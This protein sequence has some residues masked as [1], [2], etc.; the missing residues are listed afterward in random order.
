LTPDAD[1]GS[2]KPMS[3]RQLTSAK[4]ASAP[5]TREDRLARALRANLRRRKAAARKLQTGDCE[6]RLP[7]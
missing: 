7:S 2:W 6:P 3:T 4:G 1:K 5:E